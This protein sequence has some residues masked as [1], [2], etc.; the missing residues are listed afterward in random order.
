MPGTIRGPLPDEESMYRAA[1]SAR[2]AELYL[3][4]FKLHPTVL[5]GSVTETLSNKDRAWA[6]EVLKSNKA[7]EDEEREGEWL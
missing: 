2:D 1:V 3:S 7:K 6:D 5:W 4:L